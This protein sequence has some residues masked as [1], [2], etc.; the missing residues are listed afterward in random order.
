MLIG[1]CS[2]CRCMRHS[3]AR[4]PCSGFA[5]PELTERK[6]HVGSTAARTTTVHE[7]GSTIRTIRMYDVSRHPLHKMMV[8]EWGGQ[9]AWWLRF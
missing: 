8:G 6:A 3:A 4:L 2:A 9:L 1:A 5:C 7:I